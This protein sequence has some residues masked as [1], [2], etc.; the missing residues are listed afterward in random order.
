ML[1][2]WLL[3]QRQKALQKLAATSL[4][5]LIFQV[6]I[7]DKKPWTTNPQ[8]RACSQEAAMTPGQISDVPAKVV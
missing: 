4:E 1:A 7:M 2:V 8:A 5:G 6:E 3:F